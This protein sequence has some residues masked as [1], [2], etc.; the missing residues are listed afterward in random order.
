LLRFQLQLAARIQLDECFGASTGIRPLFQV[1][2][3]VG[4]HAKVQNPAL[5]LSI[6]VD[7]GESLSHPCMHHPLLGQDRSAQENKTQVALLPGGNAVGMKKDRLGVTRDV[8][9][10]AQHLPGGPAP[11]VPEQPSQDEEQA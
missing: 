9:R 2:I 1:D 6:H 7:P 3:P 11:A 4:I 8:L 5:P 10:Q